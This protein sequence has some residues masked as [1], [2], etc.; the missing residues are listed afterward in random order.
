MSLVIDP[1]QILK[2]R[3]Q[4]MFQ[5]FPKKILLEQCLEIPFYGRG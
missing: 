5:K 4:M 3:H 2:W 1:L